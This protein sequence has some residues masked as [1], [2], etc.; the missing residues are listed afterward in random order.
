MKIVNIVLDNRGLFLP[1]YYLFKN[2]VI[3]EHDSFLISITFDKDYC[4]YMSNLSNIE[5]QKKII[6]IKKPRILSFGNVSFYIKLIKEIY[7]INPDV[8]HI[9]SID[10]WMLP[11]IP[12]LLKYKIVYSIHDSIPHSGE[13]KDIITM[14]SHLI[15]SRFAQRIMFFS[16][17]EKNKM[18]KLYKTNPNKTFVSLLGTYDDYLDMSNKPVIK[19]ESIKYILF[20]GR[21]SDYKGIDILLKSERYLSN[22][23]QY[24]IIISGVGDFSKY[25]YLIKDINKY[26]ILNEY[27]NDETMI[28]LFKMADIIVLPYRESSQSAIFSIAYLFNKPV[29]ISNIEGLKEYVINNKT[30]LIFQTGNPKDLARMINKLLNDTQLIRQMDHNIINFKETILSWSK[31]TQNVTYH[32]MEILNES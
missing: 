28:Q 23:F 14:I 3:L 4:P 17:S 18:I 31:I 13:N 25:S 10:F 12:L 27:I 6:Q 2:Q 11:F 1:A 29:I 20:F 21:I 24:K 8:I 30:G 19:N 32:Y 7:R 5:L 15:F 26:W 9:H 16:N 22:K